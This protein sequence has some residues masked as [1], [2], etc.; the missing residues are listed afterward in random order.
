MSSEGSGETHIIGDPSKMRVQL[1]YDME[2]L[3]MGI[4]LT[5]QATGDAMMAN[6]TPEM[7][8]QVGD[9]MFK[10]GADL[11]AKKRGQD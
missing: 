1:S 2:S 3:M 7:A 10:I 6:I 9:K 4:K 11:R 5:D 8:M